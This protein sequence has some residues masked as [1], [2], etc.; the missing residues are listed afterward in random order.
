MKTQNR[1]LLYMGKNAMNIYLTHWIIITVSIEIIRL[2]YP[3][4]INSLLFNFFREFASL[5]TKIVFE[6]KVTAHFY[7]IKLIIS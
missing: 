6:L 3:E 2:V 7:I 1:I 5:I 4:I